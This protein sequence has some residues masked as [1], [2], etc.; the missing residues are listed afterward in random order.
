MDKNISTVVIEC[1]NNLSSNSNGEQKQQCLGYRA[2]KS[3]IMAGMDNNNS[4]MGIIANEYS[5][6][7]SVWQKPSKMEQ[8]VFEQ[9]LWSAHAQNFVDYDDVIKAINKFNTNN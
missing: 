5:I 7:D 9:A 6:M 2:G 8:I 3:G 1:N 4:N